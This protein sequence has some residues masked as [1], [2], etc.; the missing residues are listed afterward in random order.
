MPERE[1]LT[2]RQ[3]QIIT[4]GVQLHTEGIPWWHAIQ[5]IDALKGRNYLNELQRS[6]VY[7][8]LAELQ[9]RGLI[10]ARWGTPED[11]EE[12]R[13]YFCVSEDGKKE[14][15]KHPLLVDQEK[16]PLIPVRQPI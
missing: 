10:N 14:R 5:M 13:R 3:A 12:R 9:G 6:S 8:G 1:P 4:V 7:V 2:E 15:L 11:P 16:S